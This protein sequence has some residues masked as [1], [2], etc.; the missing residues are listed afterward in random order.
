MNKMRINTKKCKIMRI[1]RKKSPLVGDYNIE[2]QPLESVDVYKE[3]GLITA[4]NLSWNKHVDKI[5]A[6]ANRV[7]GLVKRTCRDLKDIDTMNTLYCSLVRPLLQYSC[8]T[9]NPHTTRN[10]DKLGAVQLRATRWITKCDDDY[11]IRL[12]KLKT[13][14]L[15]N[16]RF[17]RDVTFFNVINGHYDIDISNKLIFCK[18]RN[19][20]YNLRKNDTQDLVP[21]FSRTDGF[22]YSFLTVL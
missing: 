19:I 8:E 12:S 14:S 20:G 2:G 10:I 1:T 7:L 9:W 5:T 16:R 15:S 4:S 13:L 18:D 21:N 3:Y 17:T 6:K 22:K 11:D